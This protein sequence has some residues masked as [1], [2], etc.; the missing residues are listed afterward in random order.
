[1]LKSTSSKNWASQ[2]VVEE[3]GGSILGRMAREGTA[4][5]GACECA[6]REETHRWVSVGRGLMTSSPQMS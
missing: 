1:M 6:Q 4:K 5:S 2:K 3:G